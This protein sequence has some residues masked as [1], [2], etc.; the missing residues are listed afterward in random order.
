P[1]Y[2]ITESLEQ[3]GVILFSFVLFSLLI[4]FI[5][6]ITEGHKPD[7]LL[8]LLIFLLYLQLIYS[9]S[10]WTIIPLILMMFV[11]LNY[12][13][14]PTGN[15]GVIPCIT[16]LMLIVVSLSIIGIS[17]LVWSSNIYEKPA[18]AMKVE[19]LLTNKFE[20]ILYEKSKPNGISHDFTQLK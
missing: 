14:Q 11:L 12:K 17:N 4:M 7:Y 9:E 10:I 8:G 18:F 16:A 20:E 15:R 5:E 13:L 3:I 2:D 1:T 19:G 6:T